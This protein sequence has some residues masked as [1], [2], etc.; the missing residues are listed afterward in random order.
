MV[1]SSFEPGLRGHRRAQTRGFF[2]IVGYK[3]ADAL[4]VLV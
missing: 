3:R 4:F 1:S 2:V